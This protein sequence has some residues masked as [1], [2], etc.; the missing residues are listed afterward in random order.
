LKFSSASVKSR[1]DYFLDFPLRFTIDN[2]RWRSFE[3]R[4]MGL[5]LSITGQEVDVENGVDLH[6]RG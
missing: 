4:T 6:R 5:G 2:V 1:L 3:V